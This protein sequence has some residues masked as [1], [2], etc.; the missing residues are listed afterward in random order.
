MKPIKFDLPLN[1]Q[2]ISNLE[3]L[4]ENLTPEILEHFHSGKLLKWLRSRNLEEQAKAIEALSNASITRK[5]ELF[6]KICQI[7]EGKNNFYK[8]L[9]ELFIWLNENIPTFHYYYHD[10]IELMDL[11]VLDLSNKQLIE[12]PKC[13]SQLTNL[14]KLDLSN[15][16]LTE[17]SK[18]IIQLTN[19]EKLNLSNNKLTYIPESI[20]QLTNLTE[21]DLSKNLLDKLPESI[22]NLTKL[23]YIYLGNNQLVELPKPIDYFVNSIIKPNFYQEQTN[24]EVIKFIYKKNSFINWF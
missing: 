21:L 2:K 16:Q 24:Q 10:E 19:L 11:M 8:P 13:I 4:K 7:C 18:D 3:Q 12:L 5:V 9:N 22:C 6:N 1:G 15:N 20:G 14:I 23:Q 17:L